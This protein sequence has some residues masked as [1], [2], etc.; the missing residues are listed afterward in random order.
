MDDRNCYLK[1]SSE[2][3]ETGCYKWTAVEFAVH[4]T[5]FVLMGECK[6]SET[7]LST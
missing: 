1:V 6:E 7:H 3:K 2:R 4:V 5:I